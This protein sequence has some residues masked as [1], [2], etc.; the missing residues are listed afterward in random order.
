MV[1]L[2]ENG[3]EVNAIDLDDLLAVKAR[4]AIPQQLAG[5]HTAVVDDYVIEGHV[6]A[7]VIRRLLSERPDVKGLSVPGMPLGSPG[8][9]DPRGR[10]D[11]FNVLA[12]DAQGRAW[13]YERR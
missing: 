7:D 10:R 2:R 9:E 8:M 4:Y 1:H 5:C 12:F 6:P 13:V 3:F 11:P